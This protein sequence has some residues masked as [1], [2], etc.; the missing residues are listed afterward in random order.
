MNRRQWLRITVPGTLSC[1]TGCA[2]SGV[3]ST[4]SDGSLKISSSTKSLLSSA[5][6]EGYCVWQSGKVIESRNAGGELGALS[7]T[8]AIAALAVTRAVGEGW[9][10]LDRTLTDI[11]PEWRNDSAKSRVTIRM[12]VNQ[13][14]GFAPSAG[15]LYRGKI[16][17]K[18]RVAISLPLVDP[19]GTRFRY[20][21]ACWEILAEVLHRKLS[22]RGRTLEKFIDE[23]TRRM[24]MR[25]KDWREDENGR[26]YLS[27][28]A[29]YN[30]RELGKLGHTLGRLVRGTND[31][32]LNAAI[33]RDL[34]SPRIANPMFGA[35]LWW[36]RNAGKGGAT[37][38][39]PER[40][41]DGVHDPSFWN[42][43]CLSSGAARGWIAAIGSGGKRVYVLPEKDIVIVRLG[44]ALGWNDRALLDGLTL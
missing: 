9:L 16:Q 42:R 31:A 34:A 17:N 1:L 37:A 43:A 10:S 6:A 24:G 4:G 14:A 5:G 7:L 11:I 39:D 25:S 22:A 35:G 21:P 41:L 44:R 40:H 33:F 23:V 32:E 3:R 19:P 38:I 36:N 2:S 8:K 30:I 13:S 15:P 20:G 12:L 28:G 18:G 29:E 26:Y 27:T